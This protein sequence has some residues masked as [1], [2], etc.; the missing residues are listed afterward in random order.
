MPRIQKPSTAVRHRLASW[1]SAWLVGVALYFVVSALIVV[2]ARG[3]DLDQLTERSALSRAAGSMDHLLWGPYNWVGRHLGTG[4][5]RM[6]LVTPI[7]LVSNAL[8]WGASLAV[9]GRISR[10]VAELTRTVVG[11]GARCAG[12]GYRQVTPGM[13]LS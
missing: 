1:A 4:L 5:L 12:A 10:V 13:R 7:L 2:I 8:A 11:R 6:R 3:A 9:M